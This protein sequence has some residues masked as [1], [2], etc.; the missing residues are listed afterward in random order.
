MGNIC[1][2]K[3]MEEVCEQTMGHIGLMNLVGHRFGGNY[4]VVIL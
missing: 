2:V 1:T 3:G 4:A